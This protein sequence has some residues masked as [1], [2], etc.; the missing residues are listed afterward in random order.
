MEVIL[1]AQVENLGKLGDIVDVRSGYARNYLLPYGKAQMVTEEN[2]AQLQARKAELEKKIEEERVQARALA[3]QIN[4][5]EIKIEVGN[6]NEE[7]KLP[8]SI[9]ITD[10]VREVHSLSGLEIERSQVRL[11]EGVFRKVGEYSVTI[12]FHADVDAIIKLSIIDKD[13]G[14]KQ[15]LDTPEEDGSGSSSE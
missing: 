11:P 7:G 4:E 5:K 10:I 12:H 14:N 3:D 1:M 15:A 13:E 6:V 9:G 2:I 8:G